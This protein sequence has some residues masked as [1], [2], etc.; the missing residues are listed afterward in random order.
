M[1]YIVGQRVHML[2][3]LLDLRTPPNNYFF[4][5]AKMFGI[6]GLFVQFKHK[7]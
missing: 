3:K 2:F 7:F 5:G 6:H 4:F 1:A